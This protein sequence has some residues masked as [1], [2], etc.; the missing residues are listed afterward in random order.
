MTD[1]EKELI[2][3]VFKGLLDKDYFFEKIGLDVE[4]RSHYIISEIKS[5]IEKKDSD[6]LDYAITLLLWADDH[7][8]FVDVLNELLLVS[9]HLHH[10]EITR[11]LQDVKSPSSIP[12]IRKVLESNF[13]YLEYTCS[14][15]NAIAKWFSWALY[16]IGTEEA[17][18]LMKEYA[19][20]KDEGIREEMLYRLDKIES[21]KGN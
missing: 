16:C 2:N 21:E 3:N 9:F 6:D 17:I 7:S 18:D 14:E 19:N 5:A 8:K 12:F 10:Q 4:D 20:S 1:Y 13:E 15:S 11:I